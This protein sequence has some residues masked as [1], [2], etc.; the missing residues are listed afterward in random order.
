M[1]GAE[2]TSSSVRSWHL[3]GGA[4]TATLANMNG[5]GESALPTAPAAEG[6]I[7]AT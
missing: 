1:L 5:T 3:T 2:A 6:P 4:V 7:P